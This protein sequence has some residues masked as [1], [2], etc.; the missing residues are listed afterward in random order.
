MIWLDGVSVRYAA[1]TA[2][3]PTSVEFVQ[4]Q[5]TVLLGPSGAGKS[6][7]LRCINLLTKP[8]SGAVSIAGIGPLKDRQS[9]EKHRRNTAMIFQQH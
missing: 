1:G 6:T 9:I 5:C 7:L 2:L 3:H 8:S 4:G